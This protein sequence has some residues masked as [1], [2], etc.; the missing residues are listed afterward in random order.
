MAIRHCFLPIPII[1]CDDINTG[2][3]LLP[4][5]FAKVSYFLFLCVRVYDSLYL[6]SRRVWQEKN[7]NQ[8]KKGVGCKNKPDFCLDAWV[9]CSNAALAHWSTDTNNKW[10]KNPNQALVPTFPTPPWHPFLI[11]GVYC[12]SC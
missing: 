11:S 1:S 9:D 12:F 5:M 10:K 8:I 2:N 4:V 6:N 3:S 7:P